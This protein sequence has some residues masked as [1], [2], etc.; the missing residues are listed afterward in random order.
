MRLIGSLQEDHDCAELLESNAW[1]LSGGDHPLRSALVASGVVLADAF[2]WDWIPDQG[3]DFVTVLDGTQRAL[4]F[5]V[6]RP[7]AGPAILFETVDFET[8]RKSIAQSSLR[9]QVRF[10]VLLDLLHVGPSWKTSH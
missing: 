5:E 9:H 3:E 2:V 10:A 8:F 1:F 7:P 6:P 4:R